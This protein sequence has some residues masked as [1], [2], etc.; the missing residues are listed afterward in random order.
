ML[1]GLEKMVT[2]ERKRE[3]GEKRFPLIPGIDGGPEL[4]LSR[5]LRFLRFLR[6]VPVLPGALETA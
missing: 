5:F 1:D 3:P 2:L 6:H 4:R